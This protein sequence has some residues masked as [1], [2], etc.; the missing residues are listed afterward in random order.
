M[1]HAVHLGSEK[2]VKVVSPSTGSAILKKVRRVIRN[3]ETSDN[4]Y[5]LNQIN[6]GLNECENCDDGG[7]DPEAAAD[8]DDEEFDVGDACGKALALVKQVCVH[9][10]V[11]ILLFIFCSRSASLRKLVLFS[12][13]A[14]KRLKCHFL[15]FCCGSKHAGP[16]CTTSST[17]S[18]LFAR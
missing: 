3:A 14:A 5:D 9:L 7:D 1:E 6:A 4:T 8:D 18:L 16:L 12:S 2:F 11:F 17:G 15:S 10:L 13:R